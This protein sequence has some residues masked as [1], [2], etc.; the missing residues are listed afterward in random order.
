[1]EAISS[2]TAVP[3]TRTR[4]AVKR[5]L[6]L[7]I[8]KEDSRSVRAGYRANDPAAIFYTCPE[9]RELISLVQCDMRCQII[10]FSGCLL[11][12][13]NIFV[14]ISG[15]SAVIMVQDTRIKS[16]TDTEK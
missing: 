1:M 7:G 13:T 6:G 3:V 8:I 9:M 12:K 2:Q 14:S 4:N 16:L 15:M 5:L 10:L 11:K